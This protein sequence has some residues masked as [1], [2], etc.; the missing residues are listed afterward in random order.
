MLVV[1]FEDQRQRTLAPL[2]SLRP[3]WRLKLGYGELADRFDASFPGARWWPRSELRPLCRRPLFQPGVVTDETVFVNAAAADPYAVAARAAAEDEAAGEFIEDDEGLRLVWFRTPAGVSPTPGGLEPHQRG[4][5]AALAAEL[6]PL[7]LNPDTRTLLRHPWELV[8]ANAD[9]LMGGFQNHTHGRSGVQA[10]RIIGDFRAVFIEKGADVEPDV[11]FDTTDGPVVVAAGAR[12]KAPARLEGP[13]FIGPET[14]VDNAVIRP[15]TS[16]GYNCRI[17]GELE[18]CLLSDHVN[19]H[20]YGFL[21][22]A[23]LG[24]WVNL[25]A[26]TTN[27]DLKN[28]YKSVRVHTPT[29]RVDS[30]ALKLGCFIGDHTKTGIGTLIGT[31]TSIGAFCNIF[32]VGTLSGW[33]PPFSWLSRRGRSVYRLEQALETAAVVMAR[34]NVTLDDELRRLIQLRF[35]ENDDEA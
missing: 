34:R 22:H 3:L 6:L 4:Y 24:E 9:E 25:G 18:A 14:L 29:G 11:I 17:S 27:S 20:H 7:A 1:V 19:K 31:G 21:G 33:L 8:N 10:G 30:G 28:N 23:Y 15:G 12:L 35:A 16:I 32:D 5:A 26:G 13:C 2:T